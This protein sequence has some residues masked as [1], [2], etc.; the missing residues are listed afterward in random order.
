MIQPSEGGFL[1]FL[2]L[3]IIKKTCLVEKFVQIRKFGIR[4]RWNHAQ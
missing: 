2:L 1:L 3:F 4:E